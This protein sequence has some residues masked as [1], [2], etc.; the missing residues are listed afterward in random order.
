MGMDIGVD[1][2]GPGSRLSDDIRRGLLPCIGTAVDATETVDEP[3]EFGKSEA[4]ETTRFPSPNR[5]NE[6]RTSSALAL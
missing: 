3:D 2:A 4:V 5:P 6:V 1:V